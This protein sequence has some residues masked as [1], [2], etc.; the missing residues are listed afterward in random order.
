M[1]TLPDVRLAELTAE[2]ADFVWID[3]EHGALGTADVQ[4]LAVAARAA[5]TPALVRVADLGAPLEAILDAGV[6]GVVMPRVETA[7]D[8]AAFVERTRYP[9]RGSRG[10]AGRRAPRDDP[11]GGSTPTCVVQIESWDAARRAGEIAEVDGVDAL[12]V[13]CADLSLS[14]GDDP[15]AGS[16]ALGE[17]IALVQDAAALAGRASGVAGAFDAA[18]LSDLVARRTTCIVAAADVRVYRT[19]IESAL[20]LPR[21]ALSDARA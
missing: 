15:S 4:P 6:D 7:A 16:P 20:A 17:A 21:A 14:L 10:Y 9:P 11:L 8:A 2:P 19:A 5:G 12:V 3:L 13:G 1:I 18:L